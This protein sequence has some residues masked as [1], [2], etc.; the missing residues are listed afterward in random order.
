MPINKNDLDDYSQDDQD[1]VSDTESTI[2]KW[3]VGLLALNLKRV[4]T[5]DPVDSFKWERQMLVGKTALNSNVGKITA[6]TFSTARTN[7]KASITQIS[8]K[9]PQGNESWLKTA[10]EQGKLKT[11]EPLSK[12]T[13]VKRIANE[14][15]KSAPKYLT[16]A[17][18][19]MSLNASKAF[20]GIVHDAALSVRAKHLL[21]EEALKHAASEW[22]NYGIPALIDKAGKRW[23]PDVYLRMVFGNELNNLSNE[24]DL[25]RMKEYGASLVK[26][27]THAASRPSHKDYQGHIYDFVGD[28]PEYPSISE[29]GYGSTTGIGGLN[30][31][32]YLMPYVDGYGSHDAHVSDKESDELYNLTQQQRSYERSVRQ[33]K[34][35]QLAAQELGSSVDVDHATQL[36]GRRQAKLRNFTTA[37]NLT[38]QRDREKVILDDTSQE[39]AAILAAQVKHAATYNSLIEELGEHGLPK[40]LDEYRREVYNNGRSKTL[41]AYVNSR[42]MGTVEPVIKYEDYLQAVKEINKSIIGITT[43]NGQKITSFSDHMI[44]RIFGAQHDASHNGNK[45][46]GVS[47]NHIKSLLSSGEVKLSRE[48]T[49]K[50]SDDDTYVIVSGTGN[51]ITVIPQSRGKRRG[52]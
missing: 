51:I 27:S 3:I 2:W 37:N 44:E 19:N 16:L 24:V 18:R 43:L 48:D 8:V 15:Q 40:T 46:V 17:Q 28:S 6:S 14:A 26:V 36:L 42:L 25:A 39:T 50:Y 10:S 4:K 45:R 31:R 41:H 9:S 38:R 7:L 12:S 30:C 33:A 35:M 13:E 52:R 20:E 5:D 21:P 29:T 47:V 11:I 34:R 32:H 1:N 22:S 23:A 49:I